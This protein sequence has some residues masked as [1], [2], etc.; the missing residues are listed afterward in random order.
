MLQAKV[1]LIEELRGFVEYVFTN[2]NILHQFT[3]S[4]P[5]FSRQRK[6]YFSRLVLFIAWLCKKTLSVELER[7]F[8]QVNSAKGCS[9]SAFTQ[10]RVKLK[11]SF[12]YVWNVVLCL[13]FY[14]IF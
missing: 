14:R 5:D 11:A 3:H 12:F 4:T 6:L 1:Q 2:K 8:D 7:F 9:V 10:Q 13:N